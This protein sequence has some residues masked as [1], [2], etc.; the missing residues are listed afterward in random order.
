MNHFTVERTSTAEETW[1]KVIQYIF[2][3]S[4]VQ[5]K[6]YKRREASNRQMNKPQESLK[7]TVSLVSKDGNTSDTVPEQ[8][9]N[10]NKDINKSNNK[11]RKPIKTK[12]KQDAILV[13]MEKKSY[14]D[15][16]QI[17][18]SS[19]ELL[20]LKLILQRKKKR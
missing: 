2:D 17:V 14:S 12:T 5:I 13:K 11:T 18:R 3:G 9:N 7:R 15:V 19:T 8:Q 10:I 4:R 16:L 20:E 6:V 1:K